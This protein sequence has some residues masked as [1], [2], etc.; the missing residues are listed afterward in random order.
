M[1]AE[2]G[3]NEFGFCGATVFNVNTAGRRGLVPEEGSASAENI[4]R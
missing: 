4:L 2:M 3:M 1:L